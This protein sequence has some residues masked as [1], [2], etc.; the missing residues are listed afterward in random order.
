MKL[1]IHFFFVL[2]F[3][4]AVTFGFQVNAASANQTREV[5]VTKPCTK[6]IINDETLTARFRA[7]LF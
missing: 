3:A 4:F 1:S 6:T 5:T 2:L 7:F